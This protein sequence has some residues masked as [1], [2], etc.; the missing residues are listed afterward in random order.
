MTHLARVA[1]DFRLTCS[2]VVNNLTNT[3]IRVVITHSRR[4]IVISERLLC[5]SSDMM[6]AFV[7]I[8]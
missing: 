8:V 7:L 4:V 6:E 2:T 3:F 1:Y 5:S